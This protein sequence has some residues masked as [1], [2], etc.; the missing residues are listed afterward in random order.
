MSKD[1]EDAEETEDLVHFRD[2]YARQLKERVDA[3][4]A[5]TS[6]EMSFLLAV[7]EAE[8][9]IFPERLKVAPVKY[10][11]S[12]A[13]IAQARK[14]IERINKQKLQTGPN[15]PEGKQTS[16]KNALRH[17]LYAQSLM[18][19][20]KPCFSTCP[21]YP[22][23]LVQEG[24][25]KPGNHCLEKQHFVEV[26]DA[27]EK[28]MKH[29]NL[30]DLNDIIAIEIASNIDM[31]RRL[32]EQIL[33][34]GPIVKS[35]KITDTCTKDGDSTTIEHIEYKANPALQVISKL[36]GDMGLTLADAML[37]PRELAR[38][39]IDER[40]VETISDKVARMG[41]RLIGKRGDKS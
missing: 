17:G 9:D 34:I 13:Q 24:Q 15:T 27:V 1:I 36:I 14:N 2:Q 21:E 8:G 28:A 29:K 26:L 16:S 35:S 40:A 5:L 11:R 31:I 20:F 12:P 41:Q 6:D 3:G 39:K 37:T 33:H 30:D 38:H 10:S 18:S 25:T 23:A 4:E 32:K 19:L 7:T 22:C